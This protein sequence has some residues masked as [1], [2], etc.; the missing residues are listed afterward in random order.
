MGEKRFG[1][2]KQRVMK[3]PVRHVKGMPDRGFSHCTLTFTL[4][5]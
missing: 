2:E 1:V 4:D 5:G 3:A